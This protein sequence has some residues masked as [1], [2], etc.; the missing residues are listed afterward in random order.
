MDAN[1]KRKSPG[2]NKRAPTKRFQGVEEEEQE[3]EEEE[4]EKEEVVEVEE[5]EGVG[6]ES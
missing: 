5:G 4:E 1:W 3:E 6:G 2:G